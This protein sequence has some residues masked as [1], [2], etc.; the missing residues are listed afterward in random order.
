MKNKN[1]NLTQT[2]AAKTQTQPKTKIF[3]KTQ[4]KPNP[5]MGWRH[6]LNDSSKAKTRS[7]N[8]SVSIQTKNKLK[9]CFIEFLSPL[10]IFESFVQSW[11][12]LPFFYKF[13][14][15]IS[16]WV[17][18]S[19][20]IFL[21]LIFRRVSYFFYG[22]SEKFKSINNQKKFK[23]SAFKFNV[24]LTELQMARKL[25]LEISGFN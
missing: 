12:M 4:P 7:A 2:G 14:V 11:L 21:L 23:N 17:C 22:F 6:C 19:D 25:L 10:I 15:D 1:R 13:F 16:W 8:K 9:F 3:R 18:N 24:F 20:T 5:S